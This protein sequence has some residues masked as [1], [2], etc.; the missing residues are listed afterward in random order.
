MIISKW[1]KIYLTLKRYVIF[2]YIEFVFFVL[3]F[4]IN[5]G[6]MGKKIVNY[7]I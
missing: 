1:A 5:L 7:L 6:R 4:K 2:E 3:M